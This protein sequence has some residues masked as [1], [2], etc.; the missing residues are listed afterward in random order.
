MIILLL[1]LASKSTAPKPKIPIKNVFLV[2][3]EQD[4]EV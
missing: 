1:M 4:Q 2:N 3:G